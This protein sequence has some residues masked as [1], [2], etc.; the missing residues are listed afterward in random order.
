MSDLSG[1]VVSGISLSF[2]GDAIL[3]DAGLSIPARGTLALLGPSGSGK[4][5]LLRVIAGLQK[6]DRGRILIDN[7]E[8]TDLPP[9]ARNVAMLFQEPALFPKQTIMDNAL[10]AQRARRVPKKDI[11]EATTRILEMMDQFDLAAQRRKPVEVLSGGQMQ[12]AAIVRCL[13]NAANARLLMLD[14]PFQSNLNLSLRWSLMTWLKEWLAERDLTCLIVTHEFSEAAYLTENIA[15]IDQDKHSI[16]SGKASEFYHRP[17]SLTVARI[18]GPTNEWRLDGYGRQPPIAELIPSPV[19]E[20]RAVW[21]M[22]RP[23]DVAIDPAQSHFSVKSKIFLG[24]TVRVQLESLVVPDFLITAD[25]PVSICAELQ[26]ACG[27]RI[28]RALVS[29]YDNEQELVSSA[30]R[31]AIA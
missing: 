16:V 15:V 11:N 23:S 20:K 27:V 12:R 17:P 22:C 2:R 3:V 25:V 24:P 31:Q 14:E 1:L 8:V 5:S 7:H 18:V 21:C 9:Q 10:A 26:A 4:T 29:F 6:L 19:S 13:T 28:D 30:I